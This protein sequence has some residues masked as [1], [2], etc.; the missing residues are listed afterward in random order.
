MT[1]A[2]LPAALVADADPFRRDELVAALAGLARVAA[3]PTD[4][5][6]TVLAVAEHRPDL[7]LIDLELPVLG[8]LEASRQALDKSP[9]TG[10]LL[11]VPGRAADVVLAAMEIGI[12]DV[13]V[14]PS[15]P[16]VIRSSAERWLRRA[17]RAVPWIGTPRRKP[18]QGIWSFCGP[19]GGEG[20]TSLMISIAQELQQR[21][22]KVLLV[23]LDRLYGD[24][25]FYLGL[26]DAPLGP[27]FKSIDLREG[28]PQ[29][30]QRLVVTHP[31]G[32]PVFVG[33]ERDRGMELPAESIVWALERLEGMYTYVLV[34]MPVGMPEGLMPVLDRSRRIHLVTSAEA[35]HLK[36]L[37][38]LHTVLRSCGYSPSKLGALITGASNPAPVEQFCETAGIRLIATLPRARE[39]VD[40]A[41]RAGLPALLVEPKSTYSDAVRAAVAAIL[42]N[43]ELRRPLPLARS[44]AH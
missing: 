33:F 9:S 34:D 12:H 24:V 44:A 6:D 1:E 41:V 31:S 25:T 43:E 2:V 38:V 15:S 10:I 11:T 36:G 8:G 27:G 30:L 17:E 23:D 42:S 5:L 20:R 22:E 14:R 18:S 29:A 28:I 19:K 3:M 26:P 32:I 40:H 37:R 13:L 35:A 39:A 4:G 16:E 21:G 7:A